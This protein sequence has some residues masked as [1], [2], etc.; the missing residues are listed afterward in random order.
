MYVRAVSNLAQQAAGGSEA[1]AGPMLPFSSLTATLSLTS[2]IQ[3]ATLNIEG[4]YIG[5]TEN[6]FPPGPLVKCL[7]EGEDKRFNRH[8]LPLKMD[9]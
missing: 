2:V 6:Y 7:I 9:W 4:K 5:I 3:G 1:Q 8:V